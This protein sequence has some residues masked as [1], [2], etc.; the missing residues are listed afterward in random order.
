MSR[1]REFDEEQ[2]LDRCLRLFWR[3]GFEGVSV[4]DLEEASGL[5]R[6]SLYNAFGNKEALFAKVLERYDASSEQWLQPLLAPD[7]SLDTIRDYARGALA[8]QRSNRCSGCLVVKT[9]WDGGSD[10]ALVRRAQAS[11]KRAR[12]ALRHAIGRA[13]SRGEARPG[14]DE[15]RADLCFATL[16]GL[17]VLVR[18]GVGDDAALATLDSL[19][20][21]WET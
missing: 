5:G 10:P 12:A 6:Q 19:L 3:R 7:A 21:S 13:V 9:L 14:D 18:S 4:A 16:N 17:A 8:S 15:R 2:V 11:V 1:T 20:R